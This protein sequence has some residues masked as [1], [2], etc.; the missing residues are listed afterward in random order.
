MTGKWTSPAI[1]SAY[2]SAAGSTDSV[3]KAQDGGAPKPGAGGAGGAGADAGDVQD[4]TAQTGPTRYAPMQDAPPAKISKTDMKP[5]YPSTGYMMAATYL[6]TPE[7]QTTI[8]VSRTATYATKENDVSRLHLL[9]TS[10]RAFLVGNYQRHLLT[11]GFSRLL[12]HQCQHR[13]GRT[14][15]AEVEEVTW[16]NSSGD[17][18]TS[19]AL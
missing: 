10:H 19:S 12:P 11:Y 13:M 6:P 1:Q 14:T 16:Q 5:L 4:Y 9:W 8:T 18:K 15:P 3:P 17:G 2:Q 7:A